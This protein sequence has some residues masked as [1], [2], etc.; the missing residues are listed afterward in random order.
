MTVPS[1]S[2]GSLIQRFD[3]MPG[4]ATTSPI[5]I[6]RTA[7]MIDR[8]MVAPK[9]LSKK[10]M[11]DCPAAVVGSI[12]YQPQ[13]DP[14]EEQPDNRMARATKGMAARLIAGVNAEES[15]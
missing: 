11:F 1:I 4:R 12:T 5:I 2:E 14:V 9:P 15:G 7:A 6:D 3:D 10:R 8:R 13:T